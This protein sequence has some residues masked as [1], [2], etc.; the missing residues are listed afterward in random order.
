MSLP[1]RISSFLRKKDQPYC[2]PCL[3]ACLMIASRDAMRNALQTEQLSV[4][5]GI[6]C[7]CR[8]RKQV[9]RLKV[10]KAA[11][12]T[13]A[14]DAEREIASTVTNCAVTVAVGP[15][16]EIAVTQLVAEQGDAAV[17]RGAFGLADGGAHLREGCDESIDRLRSRR[18][19]GADRRA[20]ERRAA[21]GWTGRD[22]PPVRERRQP[23]PF[24]T[25]CAG[26]ATASS[27]HAPDAIDAALLEGASAAKESG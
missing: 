15:V 5:N 8:C 7:N 1:N 22:L 9:V 20:G 4:G 6:C 24:R 11:A 14:C 26:A 19:L 2:E 10:E 16:P 18:A 25:S 21:L 13:V 27:D 3:I 23:L 17:L 12:L